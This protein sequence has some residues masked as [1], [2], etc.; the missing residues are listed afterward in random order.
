M[1]TD[2]NEIFKAAQADHERS[3]AA[4]QRRDRARRARGTPP[5]VWADIH[6]LEDRYRKT[7][8]SID[9]WLRDPELNFPKPRLVRGKRLWAV[10]D[11]E[12]FDDRLRE[13]P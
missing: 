11:L 8:S 3:S 13:Q 10:S 5:L 12:A 1:A 4:A 2:L 9:R 6:D 7:K